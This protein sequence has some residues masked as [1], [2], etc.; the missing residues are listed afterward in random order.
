MDV[1]EKAGWDFA[2]LETLLDTEIAILMFGNGS[3]WIE[4]TCHVCARAKML[5]HQG[6]L[7]KR[8]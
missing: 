2:T 4:R 5:F 1:L 8:L 7:L 3:V 6:A